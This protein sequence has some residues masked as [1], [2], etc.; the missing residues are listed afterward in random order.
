MQELSRS[1]ASVDFVDSTAANLPTS[2]VNVIVLD[3][4]SDAN[5]LTSFGAGNAADLIARRIT[6]HGAG[7]F[8]YFNQARD[9]P[10]LGVFDGPQQ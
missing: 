1:G 3:F 6:A 7:F 5:P 2:G 10:R 8:V 4:D 9:L